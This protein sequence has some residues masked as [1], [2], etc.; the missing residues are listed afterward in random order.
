MRWL[1]EKLNALPR[2]VPVPPQLQTVLQERLSGLGHLAHLA[3]GSLGL[4]TAERGNA[5]DNARALK[6]LITIRS[7]L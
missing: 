7:T 2:L 3:R 1:E 6:Q 4:A 5:R